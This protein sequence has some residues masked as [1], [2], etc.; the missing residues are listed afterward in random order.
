MILYVA[1]PFFFEFILKLI[2]GI[3]DIKA[4]WAPCLMTITLIIPF[5]MFKNKEHI[6]KSLYI[7]IIYLTSFINIGHIIIFNSE[8]SD[9]SFMTMFDSNFQEICEF[10]QHFMSLKFIVLS[11]IF[12]GI[13]T[14]LYFR[15]NK[16]VSFDN[17]IGEFYNEVLFGNNKRQFYENSFPNNES[18]KLIFFF[19]IHWRIKCCAK[20][21]AQKINLNKKFAI[22][23]FVI[24]YGIFCLGDH[25]YKFPFE[26]IF[27]TFVSYKI[28]A[29]ENAKILKNRENFKFENIKSKI[30]NDVDQTY[31]VV[32]GESVNKEHMS[33]YGSNIK[34]TPNFDKIANDLKVFKNVKSAHCQTMRAVMGLLCF[35]EKFENGD[36]ITFFKQA[37]F[38]TFWFSNQYTA[39]HCDSALWMIGSLADSMEFINKSHYRTKLS[40]HYD[41]KLLDNF[42]TA[43]SDKSH[44]KIIFLHLLG[45]HLPYSKRYPKNFDIFTP[46]KNGKHS[47][48]VAEYNNSILY[49]DHILQQI[50]DITKNIK[51]PSYVLYFSDHGEDVTE[52][53]NSPHT[54]TEAIASPPMYD[55]PLVVWLSDEYKA[56]NKKFI[57]SWDLKKKYKTDKI[58]YSIL[59]LSRLTFDKYN[60]V[61]SIFGE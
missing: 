20:I 57:D 22:S 35:D 38:K 23:I 9:C 42:K 17:N 34:T 48:E 36:I 12:W 60:K 41:E 46:L 4:I 15:K 8:I 32:I 25:R 19:Y 56:I 52:D 24:L 21:I 39:G 27:F 59:N 50:I 31:V 11:I 28:D 49:T 37:G 61:Y 26:K 51:T 16:E 13:G 45:S 30:P 14:L 55:I 18:L 53:P 47:R 3:S 10:F 54:H 6:I 33:L 2:L 7:P 58:I 1:F 40:S 29:N 44:K 5:I 43:I